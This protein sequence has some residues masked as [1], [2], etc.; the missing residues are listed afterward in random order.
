MILINFTLLNLLEKII[1][2][3]RQVKDIYLKIREEL[4]EEFGISNRNIDFFESMVKGTT[5]MDITVKIPV[6]VDVPHSSL[7]SRSSLTSSVP[8]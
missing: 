6:K 8:S 2:Q 5:E 7:K 4:V 1:I 3:S